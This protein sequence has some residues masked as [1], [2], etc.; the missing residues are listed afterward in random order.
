[1]PVITLTSLRGVSPVTSAASSTAARIRQFNYVIAL[2]F[3]YLQP[4]SRLI[5]VALIALA[6][7]TYWHDSCNQSIAGA[8]E[9][10]GDN[11]SRHQQQ[12]Q[13]HWTH[14]LVALIPLVLTGPCVAYLIFPI[15]DQIA[16]IGRELELQLDHQHPVGKTLDAASRKS[17]TSGDDIDVGVIRVEEDIASE[18]EGLFAQWQSW[19][20]GRILSPFLADLVLSASGAGLLPPAW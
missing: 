4:A 6:G 14:Y 3:K 8:N 18:V 12:L 13:Q 16:A 5:P 19:H 9:L 1:M 17:V 10:G 15:N 11:A 2:G 7:A 20:V